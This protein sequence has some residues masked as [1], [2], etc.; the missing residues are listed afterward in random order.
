M[1]IVISIGFFLSTDLESP[2]TEQTT[3]FFCK[4]DTQHRCLVFIQRILVHIATAG[5]LRCRFKILC[6]TS[7]L[8]IRV[9]I[10]LI[11]TEMILLT[12]G[13]KA[14]SHCT[15]HRNVLSL[16]HG[17]V[18]R[19]LGPLAQRAVQGCMEINQQL[20][21]HHLRSCFNS[22][23]LDGSQCMRDRS[24]PEQILFSSQ[25]QELCAELENGSDKGGYKK[26]KLAIALRWNLPSPQTAL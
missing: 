6:L 10:Q 24:C 5:P 25:V 9:C 1:H 7:V 20:T 15:H 2:A 3:F 21:S 4:D 22:Q 16:A 14:W 8:A 19:L 13:E 12:A 23:D 18:N 26:D 11:Y 17:S